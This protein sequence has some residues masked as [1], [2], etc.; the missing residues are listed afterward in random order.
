MEHYTN[1]IL[2]SIEWQLYYKGNSFEADFCHEEVTD[3]QSDSV[4]CAFKLFYKFFL[5]TSFM[6]KKKTKKYLV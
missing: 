1:V 5:F 3:M 4:L 6:I 2:N